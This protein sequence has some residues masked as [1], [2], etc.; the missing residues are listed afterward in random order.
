M[1]IATIL[2]LISAFLLIWGYFL[3][4]ITLFFLSKIIKNPVNTD[5][6]FQPD[7]TIIIS[8]HNEEKFIEEA[9]E[10]VY[11]S[12][13]SPE[14]IKILAG[15]DGSNDR[16]FDILSKLSGKYPGLSVFSFDRIGKNAV[17]NAL[18][19]KAET[20]I[21]FFMDADIRL[22][23]GVIEKLL[24][25]LSN[26]SVGA[27]ISSMKSKGGK[28]ESAGEFGEKF[29]QKIE[30]K[31]RI[32]ESKIHSTTNALGAFY[33]VKTELLEP[34]PDDIVPD[35]FYPILLT[36]EKRKRVIFVPEAEVLEVRPKSTGDEF[37]RRIR[38]AAS[39]M[40]ALKQKSKLLLPQYGWVALFLFSH[41][42]LRWAT[43]LFLLIILISTFFVE[44]TTGLFII[45]IIQLY[46]YIGALLGYLAEKI[47]INNIILKLPLF[48]VLMSI[49]YFLA[50]VRFLRGLDNSKWQRN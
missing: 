37:H 26:N 11:K 20:S 8:A 43:P 6:S 15:S 33:A 44:N 3:Y 35:D 25:Y 49:G 38:V 40:T 4:P 31:I 39:A 5:N 46:F 50:F 27:V 36:L 41:K 23:E 7:I 16:T 24:S 17:I 48:S 10:S 30:A 45:A 42:V 29:Y 14:K 12:G 19:Q 28:G 2:I 47:L 13:F 21:I 18:M 22:R 1:N 9:I 34:L 32:Y